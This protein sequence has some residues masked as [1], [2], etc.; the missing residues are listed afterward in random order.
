MKTLL[1]YLSGPQQSWG[2]SSRFNSRDTER[3]PTYSGVIGLVACAM[4]IKRDDT[5]A[6]SELI[7]L[8]MSVRIDQPGDI[9][10]DWQ[11]AHKQNIEI[12]KSNRFNSA[13][14]HV[15]SEV[16]KDATYAGNRTYL[17]DAK[18]IV[19]LTGENELITRIM[20]SIRNPKWAPYLGRRAFV[21]DAPL[22]FDVIDG[23]DVLSIFNEIPWKASD[24]YQKK[25]KVDSV[26]LWIDGRFSANEKP[27]TS[28]IRKDMPVSFSSRHRKYLSHAMDEYLIPIERIS[29]IKTNEHDPMNV[30][31]QYTITNSEE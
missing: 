17:S 1:L 5:E 11:V 28:I 4:G 16:N 31:M 3:Y 29:N 15:V 10:T 2:S 13:C 23:D 21:P 27:V 25:H 30:L 18:F 7:E 8:K 9:R 26:I 20:Q 14:H 24:R 6:L 22:F 19:G 12:D